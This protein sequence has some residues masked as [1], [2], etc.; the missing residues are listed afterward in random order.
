MKAL[1]LIPFLFTALHA[2]ELED[3]MKGLASNMKIANQASQGKVDISE[4]IKASRQLES[5]SLQAKPFNPKPDQEVVYQ[6]LMNS[7]VRTSTELEDAFLDNKLDVAAEKI[8]ALIDIR[9][10]GHDIFR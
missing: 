10:Q 7:L 4:G 3:I 1:F 8:K 6:K 2:S 9:N 5:L